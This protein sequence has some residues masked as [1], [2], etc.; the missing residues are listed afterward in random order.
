MTVKRDENHDN[1]IF[2]IGPEVEHTCV[3]GYKT[4][5]VVG[6]RNPEQTLNAALENDCKHVYLG[7]NRSFQKNIR[8]AEKAVYLIEKGLYVTLDYPIEAHE[9]V[10]E[11]IPANV[12]SNQRFIPMISCIIKD[13]ETV[14][15]NLTV[16]IDDIDFRGSNR[17][18]WTLG[19]NELLDSNRFTDWSEYGNDEVIWTNEDQKKMFNEKRNNVYGKKKRKQNDL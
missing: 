18:V 11:N 12:V 4:L 13:V 5:F 19:T 17:G 16:K 8:L 10:L 15:K 9:W 7:A 3:H 1:A 6:V 2:F 14:N